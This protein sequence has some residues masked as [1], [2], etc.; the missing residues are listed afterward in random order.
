MINFKKENLEIAPYYNKELIEH[1]VE[2]LIK[3]QKAYDNSNQYSFAAR[4]EIL[5]AM[6]TINKSLEKVLGPQMILKT[7]GK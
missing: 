6:G 1:L 4:S 3:L 5:R 7:T 2:Q